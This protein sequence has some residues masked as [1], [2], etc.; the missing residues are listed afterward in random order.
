[1]KTL[2]YNSQHHAQEEGDTKQ[3]FLVPGD[4]H[5]KGD[6]PPS[7]PAHQDHHSSLGSSGL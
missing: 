3:C 6:E 5:E 7:Q 2:K 4:V 1:M